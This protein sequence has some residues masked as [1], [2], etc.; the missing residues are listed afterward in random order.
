MLDAL[1]AGTT[2]ANVLAELAKGKLRSKRSARG[3]LRAPSCAEV[4]P[5]R[6]VRKLW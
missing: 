2:D 3:P 1:V 4:S 5:I 6:F